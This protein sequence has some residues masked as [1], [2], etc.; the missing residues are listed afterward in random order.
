MQDQ[1]CFRSVLTYLSAWVFVAALIICSSHFSR[2]TSSRD[3][4]SEIQRAQKILEHFARHTSQGKRYGLIIEKLSQ[5]AKDYI[6]DLE[7]KDQSSQSMSMPELFSL[8]RPSAQGAQPNLH[9]DALDAS[10]TS[11]RNNSR[12]ASV[13]YPHADSAEAAAGDSLRMGETFLSY[14]DIVDPSFWNS[15][16]NESLRLLT[17]HLSMT[18]IY[19][20]FN[21]VTDVAAD[22]NF[23][24]ITGHGEGAGAELPGHI[25]GLSWGDSWP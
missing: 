3:I 9:A 17:E 1:P 14:D 18:D 11:C 6:Q 22:V 20:A 7:K 12:Y 10:N 5:A 24:N 16:P 8:H 4:D 21:G 23:A 13:H 25:W 19:Q 15:P 2:L